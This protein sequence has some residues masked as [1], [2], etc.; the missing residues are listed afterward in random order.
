M[1]VFARS[2][3]IA[4]LPGG[5]GVLFILSRLEP[6]L[7]VLGVEI[8]RHPVRQYHR[9]LA[10]L[11]LEEVEDAFLFHQTGDEIEIGLA[12]LNTILALRVLAFVDPRKI[13]ILETQIGEDR[14]D[15][16]GYL[17]VFEDPTI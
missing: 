2:I 15:D 1:R 16:V 6:H 11:V 4:A 5:Y 14:L 8:G 17:L 13:E 7:L 12:V 3:E 10:A 9:V